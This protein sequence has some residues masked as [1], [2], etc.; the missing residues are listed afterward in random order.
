MLNT[1][2][3]PLSRFNADSAIQLWCRDKT[4]RPNQTARKTYKK[5]CCKE[6][7]KKNEVILLDSDSDCDSEV[8]TMQLSD[9][10]CSSS[11]NDDVDLLEEWDQLVD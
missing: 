3:V 11:E 6:K 4:R 1:D 7:V 9:A 2:K 10:S 8:D 5:H